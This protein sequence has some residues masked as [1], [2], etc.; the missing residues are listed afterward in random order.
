VQVILSFLAL[1]ET[2]QNQNKKQVEKHFLI[3]CPK[4]ATQT[5]PGLHSASNIS[6]S[7][8][9]KKR[10]KQR[11][12]QTQSTPRHATSVRCF[13][14]QV[15]VNQREYKNDTAFTPCPS[16]QGQDATLLRVPSN[17]SFAS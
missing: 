4:G 10:G 9:L 13:Y 15:S 8:S 2:N 5:N 14:K 7:N 1:F 16:N 6:F 11:K 17:A 12:E 3:A